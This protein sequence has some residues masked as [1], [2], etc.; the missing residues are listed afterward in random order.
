M[1]E[2]KRVVAEVNQDATA[3]SIG[4]VKLGLKDLEEYVL[5]CACGK[6]LAVVRRVMESASSV[7]YKAKCPCGDESFWK[8][9]QGETYIGPYED[10]EMV[11]I[12]TKTKD[13]VISKD[14]HGH[15]IIKSIPVETVITVQ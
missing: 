14:E 6:K 9:V 8:T 2:N 12:I 5:E 7:R 15:A 4:K 10:L 11:N 3:E 1:S 13:E